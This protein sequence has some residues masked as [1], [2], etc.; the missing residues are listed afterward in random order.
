[1]D[2]IF[3]KK[4]LRAEGDAFSAIWFP[5]SSLKDASSIKKLKILVASV[6]ISAATVVTAWDDLSRIIFFSPASSGF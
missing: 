4:D 6:S 5:A 2:A 1:M 3:F